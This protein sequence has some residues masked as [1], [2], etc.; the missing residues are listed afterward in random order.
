LVNTLA[1]IAEGEYVAS[2]GS[3]T[4]GGATAGWGAY[5]EGRDMPLH[6][7]PCGG[8]DQSSW[9]AECVAVVKVLTAAQA[10]QRSVTLLIDNSTVLKSLRDVL[11][12]KPRL[13]RYGFGVWLHVRSLIG[14]LSHKAFWVPSHGKKLKWRPEVFDGD[15]IQWRALNGKADTAAANGAATNAD[16][17]KDQERADT[18]YRARAW[19]VK[20]LNSLTNSATE[21]ITN[22]AALSL[23]FGW[24][25]PEQRL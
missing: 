18:M 5:A 19:A 9:F 16:H 1:A 2:D 11:D 25:L 8:L 4:N 20:A 22:D 7:G 24:A 23:R 12:R 21:Y 6:H 10:A 15:P 17:F 13:P 14:S 3:S